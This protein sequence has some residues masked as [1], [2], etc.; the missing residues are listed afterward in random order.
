LV[1][2]LK[3]AALA[4]LYVLFFSPAE[5]PPVDTAAHIAGYSATRSR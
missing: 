2:A 5:R 1:I 4:A 3:L